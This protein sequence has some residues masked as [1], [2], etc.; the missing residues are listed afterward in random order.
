MTLPAHQKGLLG[1]RRGAL[2]RTPE[3]GLDEVERGLEG[4]QRRYV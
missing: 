1:D 2:L 4:R 3:L